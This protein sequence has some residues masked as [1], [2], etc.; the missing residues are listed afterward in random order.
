M[1]FRKFT[2]QLAPAVANVR[3][4]YSI[5]VTTVLLTKVRHECSYDSRDF[6]P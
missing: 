1:L 6:N 2:Y 4:I 3:L 5:N